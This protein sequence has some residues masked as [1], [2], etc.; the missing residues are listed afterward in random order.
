[1]YK[2]QITNVRPLPFIQYINKHSIIIDKSSLSFLCFF[3]C[4][5]GT[6]FDK[7][8]EPYTE[9][10][11]K[12]EACHEYIKLKMAENEQF[13]TFITVSFIC[14]LFVFFLRFCHPVDKCKE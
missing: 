8:F 3:V 6:Q 5:Y 13:R 9:Y 4:N 14:H 2:R 12:Q 11:L 10:C 7:I 1:M